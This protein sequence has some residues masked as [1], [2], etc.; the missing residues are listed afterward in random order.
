[1]RNLFGV[2]QS[3]IPDPCTFSEAGSDIY[4]IKQ[5]THDDDGQ[6]VL[7]VTGKLSIS[8][9]INSFKDLTDMSY[10]MARLAAGDDSV[11]NARQ[12]L[13]GDFSDL[14]YDH[15]SALDHINNARVYFDHLP[16][17]VRVKF[18]NDFRNW[19]SDAGSDSWID[20]MIVHPDSNESEVTSE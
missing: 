3:T 7:E 16:D 15:R 6:E 20:K 11:L 2:T 1:M 8:T 19:F 17:E 14:A 18:D 12:P 4:E 10:I 5:L 13:Y 9:Q